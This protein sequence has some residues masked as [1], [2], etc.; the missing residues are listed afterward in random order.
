MCLLT[1]DHY[2]KVHILKGQGTG[3]AQARHGQGTGKAQARHRQG[4]G[5][6]NNGSYTKLVLTSSDQLLLLP[7]QYFP[8]EKQP[9]VIRW[10]TVMSLSLQ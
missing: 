4:T 1:V 2:R 3:K 10:S 7:K 5:K 8:F 6:S 9:I